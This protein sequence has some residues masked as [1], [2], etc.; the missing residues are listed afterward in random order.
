MLLAL[1]RKKM[2]AVAA[3]AAQAAQVAQAE[4]VVTEAVKKK[5]EDEKFEKELNDKLDKMSPN[6]ILDVIL[7]LNLIMEDEYQSNAD[8]NGDGLLNILDIVQ[9]VSIILNR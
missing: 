3:Q 4:P 9:L 8:F 7:V 1:A 2:K 6:D 5:M